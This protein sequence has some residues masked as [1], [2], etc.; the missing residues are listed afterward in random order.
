MTIIYNPK[1]GAPINDIWNRKA[2]L[3][4]VNEMKKYENDSLA[5]YL[6][7]KYGFLREV[8]PDD[9]IKVQAEMEKPDPKDEDVIAARKLKALS[10]KQLEALSAVPSGD[11][12]GDDA[13]ISIIQTR[14]ATPEESAGVPSADGA[15][16]K[17][18]VAWVGGGLEE[19]T[20]G[21]AFMAPR[22]PGKKGVFGA[23]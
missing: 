9:I 18:G 14:Q 6:L 2:V 16:D 22:R 13:T 4:A 12:D 10:P 15:K 8:A 20:P 21:D 7:K 23:A 1:K 11:P 3:L 5:M 17:D 19:D